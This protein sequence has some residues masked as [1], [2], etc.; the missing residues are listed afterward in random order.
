MQLQCT[1]RSTDTH[2]HI[3]VHLRRLH[4]TTCSF[5]Q[6]RVR[7]NVFYINQR[8]DYMSKVDIIDDDHDNEVDKNMEDCS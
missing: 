8:S 4:V 7:K 3:L 6:Q 5:I 1:H 2:M